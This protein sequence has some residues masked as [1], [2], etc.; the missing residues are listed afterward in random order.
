MPA[1]KGFNE[2][3]DERWQNLA[4]LTLNGLRATYGKDH[5]LLPHTM[6]F[7][8]GSARPSGFNVRYALISLL[9]LGKSRIRDL[10]TGELISDLW[11]RVESHRGAIKN[12]AGDLGLALWAQA[13][14]GSDAGFTTSLALKAF[15]KQRGSLDTVHLAWVMLGADHCLANDDDGAADE[16]ARLSKSDLLRLFNP[17]ANLF[18]RHAK[19]GPFA[20]ISRRIPCFANQIYPV[21][22]LAV[23]A[24]RTGDDEAADVGR[25]VAENLC[26][27]QG[28]LGQWWWL[29]DS[30]DGQVVDG[31]PVFSVHQD[32]M[33][34]MALMETTKAGGR[35]FD[36][37]IERGLSWI[38][39]EN[40]LGVNMILADQALVLRDIHKQG[41]GRAR[42]ALH[43]AAWCWGVR[44]NAAHSNKAD[45][46]VN[47]ECRPYHL[48]WILYAASLMHAS[49]T[50]QT[51]VT[52]SMEGC[53]QC[54]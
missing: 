7:A 42:R 54:S 48:G 21:M 37:E 15:R 28:P 6:I 4:R 5:N 47:R 44:W 29:Y 13:V 24:Q 19:A 43:S 2:R 38:Y 41:V 52:H 32:G 34:P 45:Y 35:S 53:G 14:T 39:G 22:A 20:R 12:S 49:K 1:V 33:A 30:A 16:L 27:L 51:S 36:R 46:V 25:R 8:D 17:D 18:Y 9:G 50:G 23:H 10:E 3:H 11:R 40:E 26:G 31:Y